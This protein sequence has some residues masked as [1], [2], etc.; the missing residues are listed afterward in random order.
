MA[1]TSDRT[2]HFNHNVVIVA[3]L[4]CQALLPLRYYLGDDA[5]DER[6][7]WRMFSPVRMVRCEFQWTEGEDRQKLQ[8]GKLVHIVWPNLMQRA[9]LDVVRGFADYR[10]EHLRRSGQSPKLYAEMR[11]AMLDGSVATPVTD[12]TNLCEQRP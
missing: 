3:I 10:C 2:K 7:A 8:I 6:F 5:F 12:D 1:T 11:C 9:R 4:L